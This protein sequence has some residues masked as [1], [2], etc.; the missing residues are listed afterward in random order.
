[1]VSWGACREQFFAACRQPPYAPEGSDASALLRDAGRRLWPR[2][3]RP[4]AG[5]HLYKYD[6]G[7]GNW[8]DHTR[9]LNRTIQRVEAA[10]NNPDP[11]PDSGPGKPLLGHRLQAKFA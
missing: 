3:Q 1:M 2:P 5:A 7:T 11:L 6:S 4:V 8:Y 10:L 9:L